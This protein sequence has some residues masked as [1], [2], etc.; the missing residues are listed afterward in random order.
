MSYILFREYSEYQVPPSPDLSQEGSLLFG[1]F[2]AAAAVAR[3]HLGCPACPSAI[4]GGCS[5]TGG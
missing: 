3:R 5:A 2:A 1:F 4:K